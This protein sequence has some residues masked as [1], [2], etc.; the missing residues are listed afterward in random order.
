MMRMIMKLL[1]LVMGITPGSTT[2][3]MEEETFEIDRNRIFSSQIDVVVSGGVTL[4]DW[5]LRRQNV[6]DM[7][8]GV[9]ALFQFLTLSPFSRLAIYL[10]KS[11]IVELALDNSPSDKPSLRTCIILDE[12]YVMKRQLGHRPLSRN[13]P[14]SY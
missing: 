10:E 3:V 11:I 1:L 14:I 8:T 5:G 2:T 4:F 12:H 9:L 6:Y 7:Q 13:I